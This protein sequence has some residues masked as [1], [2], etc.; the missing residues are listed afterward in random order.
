MSALACT[1]HTL[2]LPPGDFSLCHSTSENTISAS[3]DSCKRQGWVGLAIN[4]AR[5]PAPQRASFRTGLPK[6]QKAGGEQ[7]PSPHSRFSKPC[8]C[9]WAPRV[10]RY[11]AAARLHLHPALSHASVA[12]LQQRPLA[13]SEA[14]L[15]L[16]GRLRGTPSGGRSGS[17]IKGLTCFCRWL[18]L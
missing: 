15:A 16:R 5:L 7:T 17:G 13:G 4:A 2:H 3:Q 9:T 10:A 8:P 6:R 12:A 1:A 11:G 14:L 18:C